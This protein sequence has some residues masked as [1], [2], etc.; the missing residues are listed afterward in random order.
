MLIALFGATGRVGSRFLEYALA[1]GH[2]K[3]RDI[4][5]MMV[6]GFSHVGVSVFYLIAVGLLSYHLAHGIGSM[7]Q[8][9]GL[10]N[11]QWT[12]GLERFAVAYC[13]GYFLLN[14]AIPLAVLAGLVKLPA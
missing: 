9:F 14:A 12:R 6:Q 1:D 5:T 4:H 8:T 3:V 13:W 11:E 10:K 7:V 2:T